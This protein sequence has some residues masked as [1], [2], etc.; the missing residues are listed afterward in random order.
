MLNPRNNSSPPSNKQLT[1]DINPLLI[2][3][4][5]SMQLVVIIRQQG[6]VGAVVGAARARRVGRGAHQHAHHRQRQ[7]H[8]HGDI[9]A[10]TAT[11]LGKTRS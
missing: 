6:L 5:E 4:V 8:V 11:L 1:W 7:H 3:V 9:T 2:I 10:C